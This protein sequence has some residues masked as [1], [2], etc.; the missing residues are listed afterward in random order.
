MP[1]ILGA[2]SQSQI[3]CPV[4]Q[5]NSQ[6]SLV[7]LQLVLLL[8]VN[9]EETGFLI[10]IIVGPTYRSMFFLKAIKGFLTINV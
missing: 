7:G 5:P 9:D 3:K 10:A 6:F 1:G 2:A 4:T 8:I